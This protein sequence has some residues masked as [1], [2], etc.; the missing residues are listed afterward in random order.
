MNQVI[1]DNRKT[2][3][4]VNNWGNVRLTR[5]TSHARTE[6]L[7]IGMYQKRGQGTQG[8]VPFPCPRI[9]Q[10]ISGEAYLPRDSTK[11]TSF[12]IFASETRGE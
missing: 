3:Y 10:V 9:P 6:G 8:R 11:S 1:F 12:S 7:K 5:Q 4:R 2:K